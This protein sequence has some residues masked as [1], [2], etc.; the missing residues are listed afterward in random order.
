M[1]GCG[2][3]VVAVA[4]RGVGGCPA[5]TFGQGAGGQ[6]LGAVGDYFLILRKFR[7]F[8]GLGRFG[9]CLDAFSRCIEVLCT[10][11]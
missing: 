11:M 9:S 3:G 8:F 7:F 2:V 1:F 5:I 6:D 4:W 10:R